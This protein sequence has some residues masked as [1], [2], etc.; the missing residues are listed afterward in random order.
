LF[1]VTIAALPPV[2]DG[3][4]AAPALQHVECWVF[5]LDNTLY[6]ARCNLFAQVDVRIGQYIAAR[7]GLPYDQARFLQKSYFRGY[8]TTMKGL[9]TECGVDPV[10]FLDFVHRIDHSPV[11]ADARLERALAALPGA[12]YVFT[13]AS[14]A[15]AEKV[16]ARLGIAHQFAD[17]F[18]IVAAG[19]EPKPLDGF[20]DR[21]LARHAL[22][23]AGAAL[24]DDIAR[25]LAP[26]HARGMTT[27]LIE[28][29]NAYGMEGHDGP[30]V[31]HRTRDLA[32]WLEGVATARAKVSLR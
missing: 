30:H 1:A 24:F 8:G 3:R 23:P 10:E 5:D 18:D 6:P 28:T 31:H 25:N 20:Y 14:V 7:F 13:N 17:V 4:P 29:D 2:V 19:F 26:A 27:V 12:K 11:E 22:A 16:L 15:H 32:G 9:M 21:F